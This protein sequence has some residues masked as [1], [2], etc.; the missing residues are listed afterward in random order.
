MQLSHHI[1]P[2]C[3]AGVINILPLQVG[4]IPCPSSRGCRHFVR[5]ML[6]SSLFIDTFPLSSPKGVQED[7]PMPMLFGTSHRARNLPSP[8]KSFYLHATED[9]TRRVER[10]VQGS[11]K[12]GSSLGGGSS[13]GSGAVVAPPAPRDLQA[14]FQRSSERQVVAG[15]A[16]DYSA[17]ETRLKR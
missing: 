3:F 16:A 8:T 7:K 11:A 15:G 6:H 2:A 5:Q 4:R 10:L 13:G 9:L 17:L 14:M 1:M 12:N